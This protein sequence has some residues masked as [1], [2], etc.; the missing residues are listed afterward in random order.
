M[1]SRR[2]VNSNVG[3]L[4]QLTPMAYIEK[5][6]DSLVTVIHRLKKSGNALEFLLLPMIHVGTQE[7]YDE[8]ARRFETCDLILAEGIRSKR[9]RLISLPY[10]IAAKSLRLKLVSQ[11]DA[12]NLS[13]FKDK[14]VGTDLA[15]AS[16]DEN[17]SQL[18][19]RLRIALLTA[20]PLSAIYLLLFVDR[21]KLA[22]YILRKDVSTKEDARD[23]DFEDLARLSGGDRNRKLVQHIEQLYDARK[24]EPLTIG[25]PYGAK[26]MSRIMKFLLN[27]LGYRVIAFERITVF[28]F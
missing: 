9:A 21:R 4:A 22:N 10:R 26:H 6:N 13:T 5:N 19:L 23:D 27:R 3:C 16:F 25:V 12:L 14:I 24:K 11:T 18:R 8:I 2:R 28:D 15:G 7:F 17:W 1:N 20:M